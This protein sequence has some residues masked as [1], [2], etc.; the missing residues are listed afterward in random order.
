MRKST[1]ST[2]SPLHPGAGTCSSQG[3]PGMTW[4]TPQALTFR[5][6]SSQVSGLPFGAGRA[7]GT[8]TRGGREEPGRW[9]AQGRQLAEPANSSGSLT[10]LMFSG[11]HAEHR[12]PSRS[13][14]PPAKFNL[15]LKFCENFFPSGLTGTTER[16]LHLT[17]RVTLATVLGPGGAQKREGKMPLQYSGGGGLRV[18]ALWGCPAELPQRFLGSPSAGQEGSLLPFVSQ[19]KS[20]RPPLLGL[21][22]QLPTSGHQATQF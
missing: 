6:H 19:Q 1:P 17:L 7:G 22:G 2:H 10:P 20:P 16:R 9:G 18:Q 3:Y 14:W 5:S 15:M 12:R 21:D 13:I 4:L 11:S 8:H